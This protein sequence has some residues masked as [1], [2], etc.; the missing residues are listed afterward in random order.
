MSTPGALS[1]FRCLWFVS[2]SIQMWKANPLKW[3]SGAVELERRVRKEV[4]LPHL[5]CPSSPLEAVGSNQH[6]LLMNLLPNCCQLGFFF[7]PSFSY[8]INHPITPRIYLMTLW[9]GLTAKFGTTGL[10]YLTL[11][12]IVKTSFNPTC[13]NKNIAARL[14]HQH[15]HHNNIIH[16]ILYRL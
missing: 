14:L 3:Q 8:P 2:N 16:K 4:K 12:N 11:Y 13:Y 10:N 9:R 15:E 7:F 1:S 6:P 5:V